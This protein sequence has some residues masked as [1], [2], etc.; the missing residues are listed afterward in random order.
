MNLKK[1]KFSGPNSLGS[2]CHGELVGLSQ[3]T[4]ARRTGPGR[5][6]PG[7]GRVQPHQVGVSLFVA[8]GQ[9]LLWRGGAWA[10]NTPISCSAEHHEGALEWPNPPT[11]HH[12]GALEWPN[13]PTL[14]HEGA[15][16]WPNPSALHH[17]GALKNGRPL[18]PRCW[19][20]LT[21]LTGSR[22]IGVES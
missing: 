11:L 3:S 13:P 6:G 19:W 4:L 5:V 14:Y 18:A 20:N 16:E 10:G 12:E 2:L 1:K 9:R 8:E 7:L 17:E 21:L 15:L 22:C